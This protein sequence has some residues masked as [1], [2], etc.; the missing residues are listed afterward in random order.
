VHGIPGSRNSSL[1]VKK[2][3]AALFSKD[4]SYSGAKRAAWS[5]RLKPIEK[6]GPTADLALRTEVA[7]PKA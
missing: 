3:K 6:N 5:W 4:V 7:L 2:T 1:R